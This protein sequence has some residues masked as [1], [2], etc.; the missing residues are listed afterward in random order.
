MKLQTELILHKVNYLFLRLLVFPLTSD[1]C[2]QEVVLHGYLGVEI[3]GEKL[4]RPSAK[5][6]RKRK[7]IQIMPRVRKG[8][9]IPFLF[10]F[11]FYILIYY[12]SNIVIIL[13]LIIIK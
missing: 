6:G 10:S 3:W 4:K 7:K 8:Y 13:L 12:Y 2:N 9:G 1:S 11:F 5:Q